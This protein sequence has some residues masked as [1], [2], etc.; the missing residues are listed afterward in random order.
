MFRASPASF[1]ANLLEQDLDQA[2]CFGVFQREI[3][4]VFIRVIRECLSA[5][6]GFDLPSCPPI[7]DEIKDV[8]VDASEGL[9]SFLYEQEIYY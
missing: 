3:S 2:V 9:D 6:E 1:L 8:D 5:V 7:V 4:L